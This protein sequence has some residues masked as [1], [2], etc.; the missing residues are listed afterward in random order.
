A[1]PAVCATVTGTRPV[2]GRKT[3]GARLGCAGGPSPR[4]A[5]TGTTGAAAVPRPVPCGTD[6]G[7]AAVPAVA[8]RVEPGSAAAPATRLA[9]G[10]VG[11]AVVWGAGRGGPGRCGARAHRGRGRGRRR[12]RRGAG[13]QPGRWRR[14]GGAAGRAAR[15]GVDRQDRVAVGVLQPH[16]LDAPSG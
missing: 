6:A 15:A 5:E 10:R 11:D 7:G 2:S 16:E 13:R 12:Q 3:A 8:T 1:G 9:P 4:A 14:A